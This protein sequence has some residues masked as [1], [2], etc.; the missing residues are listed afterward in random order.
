LGQRDRLGARDL[1]PPRAPP[2]I[3]GRLFQKVMNSI[4]ELVVKEAIA[5]NIAGI[6]RRIGYDEHVLPQLEQIGGRHGV[7]AAD[8]TFIATDR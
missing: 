6:G 3:R 2:G 4:E 5:A 8:S 1:S 7:T